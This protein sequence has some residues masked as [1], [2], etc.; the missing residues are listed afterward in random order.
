[1]SMVPR[2]SMMPEGM[3]DKMV[4]RDRHSLVAAI[5]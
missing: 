1:M 5:Y 4:G 3:P 2:V